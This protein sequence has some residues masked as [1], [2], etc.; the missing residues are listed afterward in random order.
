MNKYLIKIAENLE[1][2]EKPSRLPLGLA[3]GG[4][5]VGGGVGHSLFKKDT[6][7]DFK[8]YKNFEKQRKTA[9]KDAITKKNL[10]NIAEDNVR[11]TSKDRFDSIKKKKLHDRAINQTIT[12]GREAVDAEA[13]KSDL[14][15]NKLYSPRFQKS[16]YQKPATLKRAGK[17]IG[18]GAVGLG[19]AGYGLGKLLS[20]KPSQD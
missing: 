15:V 9:H 11:K 7:E 5:L 8:E 16:Y 17:Y 3:T 20:K 18:I 13:F 14:Y 6:Q 12:A 19:A 10:A 4:A 2:E 1:E